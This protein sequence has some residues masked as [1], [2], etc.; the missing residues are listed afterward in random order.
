MN[1]RKGSDRQ[2]SNLGLDQPIKR[3]DFVNGL[4]VASGASLLTAACGPGAGESEGISVGTTENVPDYSPSN[5]PW[6]GYGGVGDYSWSNGNTEA[7]MN[8][9]HRIRDGVHDNLYRDVKV[10]EE[11]DLVVVG[12]GFSGVSAAYEF[13][14]QRRNGQTCLLLDNHPM[15]GGE[16][17]QNDFIVDGVRLTAPQG[18]NESLIPVDPYARG[19][20]AVFGEYWRELELPWE[21]EH[22]DLAGGAE[23]YNVPE[24][25][26]MP[27]LL[28]S[29]FDV[30]YFFGKDGWRVNPGKEDFR[31]IPWS[32]TDRADLADFTNNRRDI[33]SDQDDPD[34]YLDSMS[35]KELL[36]R[37]GYGDAISDYIDPLLAVGN[38]GVSSDAISAYAAR[39]LT[40]PGTIPSDSPNRFVD[41]P[42]TSLPG[43]NAGVLRAMLKAMIPDSIEG[44]TDF[45]DI[46]RNRVRFDE[47]DRKGNPIRVR[48]A[49]TVTRVEHEGNPNSSESV[50]VT[51]SRDGKPYRVRAR[52]VVMGSGGW[53]NRRVVRDLGE[54]HRS[55]YAK[56]NYG[57]VLTANVA[58]TNW[59]FMDKLGIVAARWFE[60][61][62]W[63]TGLRRNIIF[64]GESRTLT[65][66]SP[67]VLTMYIQFTNPGYDITTQGIMARQ[68]ILTPSF[69]DLEFRI[70]EQ[71]TAMFGSAGFDARKDIAGLILNRWGHAFVSPQP[72]F[73]FDRNGE[74]A[75]RNVVSNPSGRVVFAHSELEGNMNMAHAMKQGKRGAEDAMKMM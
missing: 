70:R 49:S 69:A 16:A 4:L 62:G 57:P 53:V 68:Q 47:L 64:A 20:Y 52:S 12:G 37:L 74:P 35:Y 11:Y 31:N 27:M 61:I 28:E 21:F 8:A 50:I 46:N 6:T 66:D 60:G 33:I 72:G 48:L 25:H 73:F 13:N 26:Y 58:L 59:R 38:F 24:G 43:G 14:K 54:A 34:R 71:L 41:V 17:K 1:K 19:R 2:K 63:F 30:G 7:V 40:M 65:P 55:A 44:T 39:R 3:R 22:E 56:F 5:S 18:S 29:A 36:T 75:P 9:A 10:S 51:Y 45:G 15:L 42:I 32:K 67:V 23:K